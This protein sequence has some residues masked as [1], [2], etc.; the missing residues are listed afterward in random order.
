M[1]RH[2]FRALF[3]WRRS[4]RPS[5]IKMSSGLELKVPVSDCLSIESAW[6]GFVARWGVATNWVSLGPCAKAPRRRGRCTF[7]S[8]RR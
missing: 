3:G 2:V 1:L 5:P 8:P 7:K 6:V 4:P